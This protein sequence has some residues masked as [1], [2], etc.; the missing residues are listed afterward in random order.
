MLCQLFFINTKNVNEQYRS[1]FA[2]IVPNYH[3]LTSIIL[4]LQLARLSEQQTNNYLNDIIKS[5]CNK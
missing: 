2:I 4:L 3:R 1:Q 5:F